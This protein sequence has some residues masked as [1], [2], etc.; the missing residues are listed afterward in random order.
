MTH[1][2]DMND[3]G[4][5]EGAGDAVTAFDALRHSVETQGASL[6][7]QIADLRRGVEAAFEAIGH[8]PDTSVDLG[9]CG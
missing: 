7:Q 6:D 2:A 3:S 5:G 4:D 9:L 8:R 1:D